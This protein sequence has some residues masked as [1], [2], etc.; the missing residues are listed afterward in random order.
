[1]S[2]NDSYEKHHES[3]HESLLNVLWFFVAEAGL[4]SD[5]RFENESFD[6]DVNPLWTNYTEE[7]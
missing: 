6:C 2:Q 1:M 7:P 3:L 5:L 4:C